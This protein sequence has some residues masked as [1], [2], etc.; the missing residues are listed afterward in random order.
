[1]LTSGYVYYITLLHF[2]PYPFVLQFILFG[3]MLCYLTYYNEKLSKEA[4]I[5]TIESKRML[6]NLKK[7]IEMMP[8]GVLIFDEHSHNVLLSNQKLVEILTSPDS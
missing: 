4:F 7:V 8:E 6:D 2:A 5:E 1:M 3:G